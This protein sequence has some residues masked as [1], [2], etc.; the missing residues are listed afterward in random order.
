VKYTKILATLL[1]T[2]LLITTGCGVSDSIKSLQIGAN[3]STQGGSYNLAGV[4]R[5]LQLKVVAVYH[6]GK[7]IDVTNDSN[8]SVVV[9]PNSLIFATADPVDF[10]LG[11]L[12]T[13]GPTIATISKTGLMT[14]IAEICTWVD[15]TDTS[16][17]PPAPFNPPSWAYTGFYQITATYKGFTS[18][19]IGVGMGIATSNSPT[20]GCGP[21]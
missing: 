9:A 13:F 1:A 7:L 20:G 4:D 2:L 6:S 8:F 21:S 16:K 19:P 14:G 3:G 18:Q 15:L 5:T 10:P 17:T 11:P 12:P